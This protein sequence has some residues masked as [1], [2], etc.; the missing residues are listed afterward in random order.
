[1]NTKK[2]FKKQ[3]EEMVQEINLLQEEELYDWVKENVLKVHNKNELVL[4]YGRPSIRLLIDRGVLIGQRGSS[5]K[6][7]FLDCNTK[8]LEAFFEAFF[9][10]FFDQF[11]M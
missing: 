11:E 5:S 3:L 7:V 9:E 10:V 1:M 6:R 2:K 8:K 4:T